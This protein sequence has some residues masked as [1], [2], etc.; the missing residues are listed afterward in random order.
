MYFIHFILG[1]GGRVDAGS[2]QAGRKDAS[3]P[4]GPGLP[5]GT[6]GNR[7]SLSVRGSKPPR[8]SLVAP[9]AL[10][11]S[12]PASPSPTPSSCFLC[13]PRR[14]CARASGR[15][16]DPTV[17][18]RF[19]YVGAAVPKQS[20]STDCGVYLLNYVEKWV[21]DHVTVASRETFTD[22]LVYA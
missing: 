19:Q 11:S 13:T 9:H 5:H 3:Q 16:A 4:L 18:K 10:S 15:H 14:V 17:N 1:W 12:P 7:P 20:N 8:K 22:T 2:R 6:P 21:R